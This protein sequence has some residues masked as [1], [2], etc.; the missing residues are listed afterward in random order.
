MK[1][2]DTVIADKLE[3]K[4]KEI[5]KIREAQQ[6][7]V[8]GN[9]KGDDEALEARINS[10]ITVIKEELASLKEAFSSLPKPDIS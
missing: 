6:S 10:Q 7:K 3:E 4:D 9:R 2:Y 1:K 5:A 8:L